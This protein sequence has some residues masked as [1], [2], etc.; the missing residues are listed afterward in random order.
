MPS[1]RTNPALGSPVEASPVQQNLG[2]PENVTTN[3]LATPAI[4]NAESGLP[5][6]ESTELSMPAELPPLALDG[7]CAVSI[8]EKTEWNPGDKQYGAIHL[9]K[10]YLFSSSD[11]QEKFLA[12]PEKYTPAL[13]GLDVVRFFSEEGQFEGSREYG[14]QH[15]GQLYFF[16]SEET[17]KRFFQAPDEYT[18]KAKDVMRQAMNQQ[19][20]LR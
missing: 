3:E 7:Y 8:L 9:G 18:L 15:R 2:L 20:T 19:S 17:L 14:L 10:L 11:A 12:A 4:E 1:H 13:G 5:S 16:S 6:A